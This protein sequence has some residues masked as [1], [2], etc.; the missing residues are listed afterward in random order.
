M[1]FNGKARRVYRALTELRLKTSIANHE[2]NP[3]PLVFQKVEIHAIG[4]TFFISG[5]SA[6]TCILV[7]NEK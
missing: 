2:K 4:T 6:I 1:F 3:D 5:K 7:P